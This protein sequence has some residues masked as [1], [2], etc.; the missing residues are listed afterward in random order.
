MSESR[1]SGYGLFTIVH[2]FMLLSFAFLLTVKMA[3]LSAWQM[4]TLAQLG[5]FLPSLSFAS[6]K[7]SASLF[8]QFSRTLPSMALV[9]QFRDC[10]GFLSP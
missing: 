10:A 3:N 5:G 7:L 1:V 6:T 4:S 9:F 8:A 2:W